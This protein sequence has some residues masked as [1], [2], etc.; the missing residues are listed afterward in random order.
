MVMKS[1]LANSQLGKLLIRKRATTS[2]STFVVLV[3]GIAV[4]GLLGYLLFVEGFSLISLPVIVLAVIGASIV[5]AFLAGYSNKIECYEGGVM[6]SE[7]GRSITIPYG[8]IVCVRYNSI[9][10]YR[11]GIKSETGC[12]FEIVPRV[13]KS[14]RFEVSGTEKDKR[15]IWNIVQLIH[16]M[17]PEVQVGPY[18]DWDYYKPHLRS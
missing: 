17:N 4:F 7:S 10:T 15:Q 3:F 1:E 6:V 2:F 9:T 14:M 8:E 5:L 18:L 13:E 16:K 11:N 12:Y